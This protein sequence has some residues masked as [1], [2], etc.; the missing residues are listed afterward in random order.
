MT[1]HSPPDGAA[2]AETS[3]LTLVVR[4]DARLAEMVRASRHLAEPSRLRASN[5]EWTLV[6]PPRPDAYQIPELAADFPE[7]LQRA[8]DATWLLTEHVLVAEGA[9]LL[10]QAPEIL[11]LRL[12]SSADRFV[13]VM[14]YKGSVAFAGT[15]SQKL[16]VG[17]WDPTTTQRDTTTHDGRAYVIARGGQMDVSHTEFSALGFAIGHSSGV[18]WKGWPTTKSQ[19]SVH[20]SAFRENYFGA[21]TWEAEGMVWERNEFSHNLVYGLDPHDH[22]DYFRVEHNRAFSNGRHGIIFSAACVGNV[23][24]YNESFDNAWHGIVLDDGKVA[25]DG[26]PRHLRARPSNDNVVEY[27][28]VWGNEVG[29]ALEGGYR[30]RLANNEIRDNRF[31][32]RLKDNASHNVIEQNDITGSDVFAIYAYAASNDNLIV[33]NRIEGGKAGLVIRDARGNDFRDNDVFGIEGHAVAAIGA[34]AENTVNNNRLSG[35]GSSAIDLLRATGMDAISGN[36]VSGWSVVPGFRPLKVLAD[37][38]RHHPPLVIWL[39]VLVVPV[40]MRLA[41]RRR[42]VRDRGSS[43]DESYRTASGPS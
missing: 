24:R 23:I 2:A 1:L 42:A 3:D 33:R 31:G 27:N 34:V 9:V 4:Q 41:P 16:S 22:S 39:V 43:G 12:Y 14:A 7:S 32:I 15:P 18:A 36:D 40:L 20:D 29:M 37:T 26:D 6:L 11:N 8:G 10:V 21:Y 5:G 38:L 35:A 13:T 19:G 30:N 28:A 17:S 25:D